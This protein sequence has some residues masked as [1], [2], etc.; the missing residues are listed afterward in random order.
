MDADSATSR[1]RG[2]NQTGVRLFNDQ[3][4]IQTIRA[5]GPTPQSVLAAQT[6]L[7]V[8][9]MALII[10]RLEGEGLLMRLEP[11]RGKVGAPSIP[12][13]LN[14]DGA[15]FIGVSIGR[16]R[17]DALLMDFTG[18]IRERWS[19]THRFPDPDVLFPE[20]DEALKSL[21]QL[22]K[23]K[24]RPR[25]RG[26]GIAAPLS[27]GG[28][29]ELLGFPPRLAQK[30]EG[31][32][33]SDSVSQL[34]SAHGLSVHAVKDTSAACV[35]ELIV[36]NGRQIDTFLYVFIDVFIGGGLVINGQLRLGTNGNAGALGSLA[37]GTGKSTSSPPAQLLSVA[38]LRSLEA[39]YVDAGLAADAWMDH[40]AMSDGWRPHTQKWLREVAPGI[41]MAV[42]SS[43]CIIDLPC[44]II[45]GTMGRGLAQA[46]VEAVQQHLDLYPW[47]G[48]S[49]PHI[50]IGSVGPEA[51]A[52]GAALLPLYKTTAPD[53]ALFMKPMA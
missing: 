6:H 52:I 21:R 34:P 1:R 49:R 10:E 14:P 2:S 26:V 32:S 11:V 48:V 20:V 27:F 25:L 9:T 53:N 5:Q 18:V 51:R 44:V 39:R 13:A 46:L 7:S 47:E 43:A 23:P 30:W 17:L 50:A 38:S 22:L 16:R 41:A 24:L 31:L 19:A 4:V 12:V 45:D 37:L 35:A 29:G 36:G 3:I 15:F 28:W 33:I 40:R 8:Q 42:H